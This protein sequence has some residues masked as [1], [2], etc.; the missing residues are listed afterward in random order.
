MLIAVTG[1]AG[2]LGAHVLAALRRR[3]HSVRALVRQKRDAEHIARHVT[4][5]REG[6]LRDDQVQAQFVAGAQ[7]VIHLAMDWE[8]LNQGALPN[9]HGNLIPTLHLLEASHRA[10]CSQFLFV[11]SM[12][13]YAGCASPPVLTEDHAACPTNQYGAFKSAV[14]PH[15]SAYHRAEKMNASAWRPAAMYGNNEDL[16]HTMWL[17]LIQNGG[18]GPIDPQTATDVVSVEDV[19]EALALA[20]GNQAVAGQ[21][22][23]LVDTYV[24]W[25]QVA[26]LAAEAGGESP[27]PAP[28]PPKPRQLFNKHKAVAFFDRHGE[29]ASL[30]RGLQGVREHVTRVRKALETKK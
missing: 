16:P 24:G 13:V 5:W 15:L 11:S 2:F 30:R 18:H 3:G 29:S 28:Q 10:G 12:E 9:L 21:V 23:N 6:E 14:E 22:Y 20:I 17:P 19:A 27:K 7:A 4:E 1:A 8:A 25:A 26:Q